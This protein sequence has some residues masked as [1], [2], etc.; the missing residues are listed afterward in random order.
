MPIWQ[1]QDA[2]AK[3]SEVLKCAASEGPQSIT[4]HGQAVGVVL[5]Q[6]M[7]ARLSGNQQSLLDFMRQSPLV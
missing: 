2:K 6:A 7:F 3:L 1:M 5:S 4:V